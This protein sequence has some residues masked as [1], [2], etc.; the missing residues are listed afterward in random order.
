MQLNYTIL[1]GAKVGDW[2]EL[3][4]EP[5][6]G[7]DTKAAG[8]EQSASATEA[9]KGKKGTQNKPT[10]WSY[11]RALTIKTVEF[12][13]TRACQCF[14][15]MVMPVVLMV[16]LLLLNLLFDGIKVTS[17][18]GPGMESLVFFFFFDY[19]FNTTSKIYIY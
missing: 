5:I 3:E 13:K 11:L 12:Q 2:I 14:I 8:Q 9:Q 6:G 15:I 7:I 19:R 4:Y 10:T 16:L 17:M 1:E 18:C